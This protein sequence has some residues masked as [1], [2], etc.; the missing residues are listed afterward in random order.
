MNRIIYFLPLFISATCP[1][2]PIPDIPKPAIQEC[3]ILPTHV[4]C[5]SLPTEDDRCV[6]DNG[7][8]R[9]E[10]DYAFGYLCNSPDGK[11]ELYDYIDSLEKALINCRAGK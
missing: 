6:F 8:Y 4:R 11:K 1:T 2:Q 7:I 10:S 5:E 3:A 9:C